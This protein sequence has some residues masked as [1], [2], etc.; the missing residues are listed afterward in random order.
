MARSPRRAHLRRIHPC[1]YRAESGQTV[2]LFDLD[3]TL[4]D[5]SRALFSAI[6]RAMT[7]SMM[8]TLK[9]DRETADHLR[10]EYWRRY[11]ATA[12]GLVRHHGVDARAFLEESHDFDVAPL[13]H[14]ETNLR[15]KLECLEGIRILMTNAPA[16]YAERVLRRLR[17]LH[18]FD[19]LWTMD[20]VLRHGARPKPSQALMHRIRARLGVPAHRIVLIEDTLQNLKSARRAGMRTVHVYHPATPWSNACRGRSSYVDLRVNNIGKLLTGLGSRMSAPVR[21]AQTRQSGSR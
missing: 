6:D 5:S 21:S 12:I 4:H 9:V 15:Q 3:N 17:I 2:W 7:S 18:L 1:R 8:K 13:V 14:S 19:A 16:S 11:G 20:D 10:K